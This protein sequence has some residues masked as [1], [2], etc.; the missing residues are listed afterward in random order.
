MN[1]CV[2]DD[3]FFNSSMMR[4]FVLL[5][6]QGLRGALSSMLFVEGADDVSTE[7][8]ARLYRDDALRRPPVRLRHFIV[9]SVVVVVVVISPTSDRPRSIST[10]K[11]CVGNEMP[12]RLCCSCRF[13][14]PLRR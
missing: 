13:F 10:P 14:L 7:L 11:K 4:F 5:F 2:S 9:F 1:E 8:G 3:G 12:G 6:I